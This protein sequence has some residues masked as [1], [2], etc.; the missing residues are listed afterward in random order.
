M[1]KHRSAQTARH[2][3]KGQ[4]V[5]RRRRRSIAEA[6][7][8]R[9]MLSAAP[10]SDSALASVGDVFYI[11]MEN[12]N[13]TQPAAGN[14]TSA[15][16]DQIL[17]NSAAPYLNSLIQGA[18]H[19][20][21]PAASQTAYTSDYTDAVLNGTQVHPSEPNY[22]YQESGTAVKVNTSDAD[23]DP[24]QIGLNNTNNIVS[25]AQNANLSDLLQNDGSLQLG[26]NASLP[27]KSYQE[28]I[29]LSSSGGQLTNN[30]LPSNQWTVPTSS[31][32]GSSAA[33][34]NAYNNSNDYGFAAKHDGQ[35]F[36]TA[37]NGGTGS[38]ANNSPSN[39]EAKYYSPLQQLQ[40]DLT[41]N[42][43]GRYNLITPDLYN[44]MHTS[45][46]ADANF[47]Y[48][49]VTYNSSNPL[50]GTD[51][52]AIAQ[53]DN[54]LSKIIPEIMASQAY[55]NNGMIV[56]WFDETE[57]PNANQSALTEIVIS[58]LVKP[59]VNGNAYQSTVSYTHASDLKTLEELFNVP[60][61]GG[62]FLGN[63]N[64][65]STNDLTDLFQPALNATAVNVPSTAG[66]SFSGRL[67]TFTDVDGDNDDADFTATVDWGD[68][69][70]STAQVAGNSSG[71]TVSGTHT[72]ASEGIYT[73]TVTVN[74][75]DGASATVS[76]VITADYSLS[77]TGTAVN[78]TQATTF[79]GTVAT[80]T[81]ADPGGTVGQFTATIAW[82]DGSSSA[83]TVAAN[84]GGPGF[85][86]TGNHEYTSVGGDVIT[87][88]IKDEG[89]A[90]A[91]ASS[92]ANVAANP[93]APTTMADTFVLGPSGPYNA[94]GATS[95]LANDTGPDPQNLSARLVSTTT[96][97]TLTL[98]S[99][100]SFTYTPGPGFQG[101]DRFT[102]QAV[103]GNIGGNIVTVTLLSYNASLVDKLYH[104]VLHRSAEDSGLI[105]WTAQLDAGKALDVVAT[106]IFNS[107]ERLDP[108]VTQFYEEYLDRGTDVSGLNYWVA[109]W[110][111]K[112]D[113]RDVVENILASPEFFDDAGDTNNG[114]ILLLYER[115]LQRPA[116][117]QGLSYWNGLMAPPNNE[118]RLQIASQFYDTH[119]KHVD[120]VNFLF[121][122]YF[123]GVSP[124][125]D[126]TPYVN[127]LDVGQT[128]TQVEEAII[129]SS[130]YRSN[131]PEPAAGAVGRA[132]YPH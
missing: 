34:T 2:L 92:S 21:N 129:D 11:D 101:I 127:D 39:P 128:E 49:G 30:P 50:S 122:E 12:H 107:V 38:A 66:G 35:L 7:E 87:V 27:W 28:D 54:F 3:F 20:G 81:D 111:T 23:D 93:N 1:K 82:G 79:S 95:V 89:G 83:G 64:L 100:G 15:N 121:G 115:V 26:P 29:D 84:P 5:Q 112:G 99:D 51:Q 131:P 8:F 57:G 19:P 98:H 97:G 59:N 56:I 110:Q 32:I 48:N 102:Y 47:T 71:F 44:D 91:T 4:Q 130:A 76:P 85:I 65:A 70:S 108:L 24:Y 16:P 45:L 63:A 94:S 33:Y 6:L 125:P 73:A 22:V 116:E 13:L 117:A 106:G 96:N 109:D 69:T 40:N 25:T 58:P 119:E 132:L 55:K 18:T 113:P 114:Y 104:Q 42:S 80:F 41:G 60:A 62:G 53:G 43:V 120:L 52:E 103:E 10:F 77:A 90:A 61:P 118:T 72:Y 74:D 36:F 123:L 31:V 124:Q 86:V 14:G 126:A 46:P 17:N 88:T 9:A 37:T 105:Y 78:T 67:G 68:G 75:I